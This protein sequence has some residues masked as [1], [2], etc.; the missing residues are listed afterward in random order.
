M[1][2]LGGTT[3]IQTIFDLILRCL[4]HVWCYRS[5]SVP[6]AGFQVLKVVDFN[7][8][9]NVLHITPQ[10]ENQVGL[11]LVSYDAKRLVHL[12]QS[13]SQPSLCSGDS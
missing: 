7:L 9:E 10:E 6:Y 12:C 5:H 4:N 3:I 8:V 13:I 1:V 11:N 2:S